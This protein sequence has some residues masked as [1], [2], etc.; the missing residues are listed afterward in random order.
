MNRII[1][2]C[3]RFPVGETVDEFV[4]EKFSTL[5]YRCT[6]IV[7]MRIELNLESGQ[8]GEVRFHSR[9]IIGTSGPDIVA[10][11]ESTDVFDA[12][13]GLLRRADRQLSRRMRVNDFGREWLHSLERS[14]A[15]LALP[16]S[17]SSTWNML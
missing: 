4:R 1:I 16:G 10:D 8:E 3:N 11:A 12:L 14:E 13:D 5:F 2:T 15:L 17:R 7:R 6:D 9:I